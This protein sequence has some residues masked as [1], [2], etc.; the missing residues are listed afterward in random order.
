MIIATNYV[1]LYDIFFKRMQHLLR[2]NFES[3]PNFKQTKIKY[4]NAQETME[5]MKIPANLL[6]LLN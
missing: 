1:I 5:S 6:E 4:K 3:V 2:E